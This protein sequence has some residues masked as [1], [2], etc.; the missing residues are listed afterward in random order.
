[1]RLAI[2]VLA[3]AAAAVSTVAIAAKTSPLPPP[4]PS[5]TGLPSGECIRSHDIRNHTV[6]DN[7]TMLIDYNGK[8]TYRVTMRGACLAGAVSTDP[9]ITREPPG[10]TLICKPIEMDVGIVKSG[11]E[12]R[13]IVDS[14]VKLTPEEL[15]ALPKRLKP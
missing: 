14:I 12:T 6:V 3:A 13:C 11:F 10:T 15:A 5:G 9:I 7:R 8:E 1:M 4:P 2:L